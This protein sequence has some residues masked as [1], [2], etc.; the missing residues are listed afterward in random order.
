VAQESQYEIR[1]RQL[2]AEVAS[3][4]LKLEQKKKLIQSKRRST[5]GYSEGI[6]SD[7]KKSRRRKLAEAD[8]DHSLGNDGKRRCSDCAC[9]LV[10]KTRATNKSNI[11]RTTLDFLPPASTIHSRCIGANMRLFVSR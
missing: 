3:I 8:L 5:L 10:R 4:E 2:T 11:R 9:V 7:L 1:K 6:A